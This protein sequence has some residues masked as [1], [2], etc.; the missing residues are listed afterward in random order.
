LT[1]EQLSIISKI[2]ELLNDPESTIRASAADA[3]GRMTANG[4][5]TPEDQEAH[6][7]A[8]GALL[9]DA[10]PGVRRAAIEALGVVAP[11]GPWLNDVQFLLED[12]HIGVRRAADHV[13]SKLQKDDTVIEDELDD[14]GELEEVE[15]EQENDES[16]SQG[17]GSEGSSEGFDYAEEEQL[18]AGRRLSMLR[19]QEQQR[20]RRRSEEEKQGENQ[21]TSQIGMGLGF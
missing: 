9:T 2:F 3:L 13:I 4:V 17:E 16:A 10:A 14:D 15:D 18:E 19:Q 1:P 7:E 8:I 11:P 5:T 20:Q 6:A 12:P 21:I